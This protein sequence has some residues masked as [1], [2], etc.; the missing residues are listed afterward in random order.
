MRRALPTAAAL[1]VAIILQVTIGSRITIFGVPPNFVFLV[2]IALALVEGSV[3]GC[4]AGFVG[5]LLFDL[6]GSSVV[7]PHAL[8]LCIVGYVAGLLQ[9][10]MFA[11]GWTLPVSVVFVASL[12]SE[13]AYGAVMAILG[14]GV[15]FIRSF[16]AVML[17]SAVYNAALAVLFYP[18]LASFLRR[19]RTVKSF[20]RLA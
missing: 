4:I 19:D 13:V 16:V 17:P 8:V 14:V 5:G 15:P 7:G 6:L 3:A 18:V 9:A 1:L 10:N 11:E 2:V 20:R 12:G